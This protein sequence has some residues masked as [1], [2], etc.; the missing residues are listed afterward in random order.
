MEGEMT[1]DGR[2]RRRLLRYLSRGLLPGSF[3]GLVLG[4]GP[5]VHASKQLAEFRWWRAGE[6]VTA[7]VLLVPF[8]LLGVAL[9]AT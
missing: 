5:A 8:L 7:L 9:A 3:A 2:N 4:T 1:P 6:A